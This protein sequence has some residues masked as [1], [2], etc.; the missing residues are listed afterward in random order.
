[1]KLSVESISWITV[2]EVSQT[3]LLPQGLKTHICQSNVLPITPWQL[4]LPLLYLAPGGA[5]ITEPTICQSDPE[6]LKETEVKTS[7]PKFN[8]KTR[9]SGSGGGS[10]SNFLFGIGIGMVVVS[11]A[12]AA[13]YL[14]ME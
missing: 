1:M 9:G 3:N 12:A 7:T 4:T 14:W 10:C 5:V 11:V 8:T 13:V 2:V 6:P